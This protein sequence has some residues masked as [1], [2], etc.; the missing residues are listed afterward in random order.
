MTQTNNW[1]ARC[2]TAQGLPSAA[3][4]ALAGGMALAAPGGGEGGFAPS[5]SFQKVLT[6]HEGYRAN[7]Y[8]D[9]V[10]VLTV[11]IGFNLERAEAPELLAA[12]GI[13]YNQVVSGRRP[14]SKEE[15]WRLA[16]NDVNTAAA[17]AARI[18]PNF[19]SLPTGKQ[20][21]LVN[22]AFNL[23]GAK[24]L[25]FVKLREAVAAGDF[26]RAADHMLQ[27]KWAKQVGDRAVE[28]A[29]QMRRVDAS[30]ATPS[31]TPAGGRVTSPPSSPIQQ[32]GKGGK[33]VTVSDGDTLSGLAAEH[34][35]DGG[36]WEEIARLNGIKDPRGI[37]PGQKLRLP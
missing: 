2:K 12:E 21:V 27:S 7:P 36:R 15:A 10:G 22:M 17:D 20:E 19:G 33:V 35:G 28:L 3:A 6:R 18:F 37:R 5:V 23:G 30:A 11:G 4:A 16:S 31:P 26:S 34:L 9:S 29:E 24:L 14:I 8:K 13:R 32:V 25:K 1:F